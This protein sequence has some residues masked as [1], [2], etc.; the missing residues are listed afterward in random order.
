M[1]DGYGRWRSSNQ[2]SVMTRELWFIERSLNGPGSAPRYPAQRFRASADDP[3]SRDHSLRIS[4]ARRREAAPQPDA[5]RR[6]RERALVEMDRS[7]RE[8]LCVPQ[9]NADHDD[10]ESA[11][12][13]SRIR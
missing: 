6:G 2:P 8:R 7:E 5:R 4:A 10:G 12:G 13:G 9:E 3:V 11:K 1:A